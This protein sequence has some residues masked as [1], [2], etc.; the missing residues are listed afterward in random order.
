MS[1]CAMGNSSPKE[2]FVQYRYGQPGNIEMRFPRR[3]SSPLGKF[4]ISEIPVGHMRFVH[5]KFRAGAYDYILFEGDVAGIYVRRGRRHVTTLWC[6]TTG[7]D[8][9]LSA[10]AY[11]GIPMVAPT[12]VD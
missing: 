7:G 2:G 1:V 5:L 10:N 11:V 3:Q 8:A 12:H 4:S 9:V 6:D